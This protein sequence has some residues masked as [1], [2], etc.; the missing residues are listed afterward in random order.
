MAG[1]NQGM[2]HLITGPNP[3]AGHD[4]YIIFLKPILSYYPEKK[5]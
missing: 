2:C 3:G 1:D 5:P 4:F